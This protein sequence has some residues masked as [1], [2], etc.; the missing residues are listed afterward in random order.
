LILILYPRTSWAVSVY[1]S[2]ICFHLVVMS[3]STFGLYQPLTYKTVF[4]KRESISE[5]Q[6]ETV[7]C[8]LIIEFL[9]V[10][11][12]CIAIMIVLDSCYFHLHFCYC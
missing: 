10:H 3:I 5:F 6:S 12:P 2:F 1:S 8:I 9:V 4:K 7:L 11:F